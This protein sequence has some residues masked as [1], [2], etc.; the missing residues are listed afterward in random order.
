M[1]HRFHP[2]G[3]AFACAALLLLAGCSTRLPL[4]REESSSSSSQQEE[5]S[6]PEPP[7]QEEVLAA[8]DPA[9]EESSS[10]AAPEPPAEETADP[11]QLDLLLLVNA[12]NP[13]PEGYT[14]SLVPLDDGQ[15]VAQEA[16]DGLRAML[17]DA[18]AQG[19]SPLVCSSYRTQ[20]KQQSLYDKQVQ[21]WLD[22]GYGLEDAQR[23]AARWVAIP[24]TSE[25]QTGLAVDIV[26]LYNQVL[27]HSQETTEEQ[28]WLMEHCWEY[29]F[30]LRYPQ[31]KQEI[32]GITYEPWHYRY[33]GRE[34]AAQIRDSGLCLE[35][36]VAALAE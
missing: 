34:T 20:E 30:I 9:E 2:F 3:G 14:V 8:S 32:T 21:Q 31:D 36:Y 27:D 33:V 18:Q 17:A 24:G 12:Q 26:S 5:A 15:A 35:E 4:I 13:L 22:Q 11:S 29:G 25:H 1:I 19:L 28:Q 23:E 7:L 6:L 16:V 10:E